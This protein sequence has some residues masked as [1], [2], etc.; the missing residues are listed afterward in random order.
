MGRYV[1]NGDVE[2]RV[3][4]KVRFT[5]DPEGEPDKMSRQLLAQIVDESESQL[6]VDLSERYI[7]PFQT[8]AGG[9][10]STLPTVTKQILVQLARLQC[11]VRV[12]ETD[13][14]SGTATDGD[15]YKASIEKRYRQG[16]DSLVEKRDGINGGTFQWRRPPLPSLRLA[17]HNAK[18]DTGFAGAILVTGSG[19]GDYPGK[20]INDPSEQ[21]WGGTLDP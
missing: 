10:F 17:A 8:I 6:E 11:V 12:L 2:A 13:F 15:K 18:G 16:I 19:D 21:F 9:A 5:D 4:G 7:A 1:N 20:Q 3:A 14:G